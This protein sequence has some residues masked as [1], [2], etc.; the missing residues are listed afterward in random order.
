MSSSSFGNR[1]LLKP[2]LRAKKRVG[3]RKKESGIEKEPI[4]RGGGGEKSR[5][6]I[7]S[8]IGR[9]AKS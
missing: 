8:F 6:A 7:L 2:T 5:N 9:R 1:V 4:R 3:F